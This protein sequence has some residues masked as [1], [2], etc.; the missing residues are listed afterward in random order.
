M[1]LFTTEVG[2][3]FLS[4]LPH[5]TH[6]LNSAFFNEN[7]ELIIYSVVEHLHPPFYKK[8]L[9]YTA[10]ITQL[11]SLNHAGERTL[12]VKSLSLV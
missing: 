1:Y 10:L 5:I 7:M 6:F 12:V 8:V 4:V 11:R 2:R 9:M 3:S